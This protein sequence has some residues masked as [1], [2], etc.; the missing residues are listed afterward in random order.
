M[1]QMNKLKRRRN[2]ETATYTRSNYPC[3]DLHHVERVI[4][5]AAAVRIGVNE[6]R[7]FPCLRKAAVI[8]ENI[9]LLKLQRTN[10]KN[11]T[12]RRSIITERGMKQT[13]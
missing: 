9:A 1:R 11:D 8:E 12:V 13:S 2:N 4:V 10:I 5:A 7:I 6:S 3:S